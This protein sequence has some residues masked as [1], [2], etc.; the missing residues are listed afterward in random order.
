MKFDRINHITIGAPQE[1]EKKIRWFYEEVM[2]FK[3]IPH[4]PALDQKYR[5]IWYDQPNI[6]LHVDLTPPFIKVGIARHFALE[7]GDIEIARK[8]FV[9]KGAQIKEDVAV[10]YCYRFDVIDPVGNYIEIMQLKEPIP[11]VKNF[12]F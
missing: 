1:E 4:P 7:V 10:P 11:L 3:E 5:V 6:R 12:D 9:A 8:H 2:G